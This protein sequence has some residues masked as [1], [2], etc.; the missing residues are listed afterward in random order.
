MK[1]QYLTA[2]AVLLCIASVLGSTNA[3][4]K[5][6][7]IEVVLFETLAGRDAS[8]GAMYYPRWT[9]N[10]RLNTE[11]AEAQGFATTTQGL[12]LSDHAQK[13]SNSSRYRLLR[14]LSWIQPGLDAENA[15]SIRVSL[16][17]AITMYIAENTND[18]GSFI[19]SDSAPT[20]SRNA[21][22]TSTTVNG[23]ITVRLGRFLH[24]DTELVFTDI[25]SERS[26]RLTQSRKMRS[27]ELHYIDNPRFGI[28]TRITPVADS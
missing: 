19:P 23:N 1:T 20:A 3:L 18:Y 16:G 6:Y 13:I 27:G 12:T 25:D 14:H 17:E 22:V 9:N 26:F 8:G 15:R 4:A 28:L 11:Q 10:L 7:L 21:S 2:S 5:D 24:M